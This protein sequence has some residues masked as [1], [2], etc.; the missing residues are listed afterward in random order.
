[1][2]VMQK[3]PNES[4]K[5]GSED[6]FIALFG[7]PESGKF[8]FVHTGRHCTRRCDGDSVEGAAFGGPIFYGHAAAGF[9]EPADHPG[10]AYWYQAKRAN[11]LFRALDEKQRKIALRNDPRE[12]EGTKTVA[13]RG[14]SEGL[15]GI[16]V[17]ELS[18]D[19]K[20]L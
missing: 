7:E 2:K 16:P 18:H 13:V 12:E 1:G 5:P 20:D 9:N 19:Q 6:W 8:E 11:E 15:P 17:T 3:G 14:K 4:G 10:N